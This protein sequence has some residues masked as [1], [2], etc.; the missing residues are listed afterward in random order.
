MKQ[1]CVATK[2]A[3]LPLEINILGL[4]EGRQYP[5][6]RFLEIAGETGNKAIF[7]MDAHAPGQLLNTE[8]V[9]RARALVKEYGLVLVDGDLLNK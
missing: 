2:E 8:T 3:D 4:W 6:R 5:A 7:G 9:D 1:L